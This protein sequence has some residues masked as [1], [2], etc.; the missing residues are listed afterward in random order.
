MTMSTRIRSGLS[1]LTLASASK[2]SL[3][4]ITRHPTCLR[5]IS[6]LRRIVSHEQGDALAFLQVQDADRDVVQ[7]VLADLEQLVAREGVEDVQERLA[8]MAVRRQAGARDRALHL[9]AQ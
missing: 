7:L 9:E 4:R 2:P 6:A 5:K 3:A 8:V 1:A